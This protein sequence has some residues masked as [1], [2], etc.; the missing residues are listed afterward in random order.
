MEAT[1][2]NEKKIKTNVKAG[3]LKTVNH[4]QALK[5]K[6]RIKAGGIKTQHNQTLC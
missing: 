6:T 3:G 2:K 5:I 4:N 1:M